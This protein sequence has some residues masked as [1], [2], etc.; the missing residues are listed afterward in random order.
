[1][2]V[3]TGEKLAAPASMPREE[4]RCPLVGCGTDQVREVTG[5]EA[6]QLDVYWYDI[7]YDGSVSDGPS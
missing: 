5:H 2:T 4:G 6:Q 1:M 3:A 7:V